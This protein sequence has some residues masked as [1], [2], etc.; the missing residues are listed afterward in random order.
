MINANVATLED[1][2]LQIYTSVVSRAG[3]DRGIIDAGS[4][5]LTSDSGGLNDFGYIVEHPHARIH[6][7]AEE[8][9][10]LDLS[11]CNH[12]PQIGD[13]VRVI[14]NHVC[15]CVNMFDQLVAVRDNQ[16]VE[17]LP[18]EVRGMLV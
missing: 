10:F 9:G 7:F 16:I 6:K 12:K 15:V 1:C 5:T 18:V 13:I 17:V 8:H 4:K 11:G 14:P 2:A 3:E